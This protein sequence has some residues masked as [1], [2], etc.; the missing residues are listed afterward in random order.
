[1]KVSL[2]SRIHLRAAGISI[3]FVM[4]TLATG[5]VGCDGGGESY[6]LS[7]TSTVGGSVSIP[8]EGT[9][10]FDPGAVVEL[11]ATPDDGY[12]FQ[13]WT[14]DAEHV[15]DPNTAS[16]M[17]V[18]NGDYSITASFQEEDG[19]SPNPVQPH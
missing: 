3:L 16:T 4:L 6:T 8:G 2:G 18:M 7:I 9:F 19:A 14:G 13:M 11:L 1:M 10:P 15:A 5:V 12:E 17:V